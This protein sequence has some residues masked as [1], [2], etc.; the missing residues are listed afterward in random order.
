VVL[1]HLGGEEA[2]HTL[3]AAILGLELGNER[4]VRFELDQVV[5]ARGLLLDG[6]GK[7][8]L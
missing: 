5:E 6:I 4:S 2:D 8:A 3:I 1:V 7:L